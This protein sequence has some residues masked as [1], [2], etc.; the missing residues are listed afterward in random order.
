MHAMDVEPQDE[1][2]ASWS[3]TSS[4]SNYEHRYAAHA[5]PSSSVTDDDTEKSPFLQHDD[6]HDATSR[7]RSLQQ[8]SASQTSLTAAASLVAVILFF[9]VFFVLDR[10][11]PGTSRLDPTSQTWTHTI[12]EFIPSTPELRDPSEYVLDPSW[13]FEAP[14]TVR[15]YHW[16]IRDATFNPDGIFRPMMLINNKFPG[17]LIKCNEGDTIVVHVTN[18]AANATAI[19]FHGMFQNGTNSMDG[20]VGVTQCPIA[21]NATFTYRFTVKDQSGTYWYHAHHSVQASDG[22]VGPMVVR[23]RK[24]KALAG[25]YASDRVVMIQDHYHNTSAELLMD[26]LQPDQ[27]NDEPVPSS[28]LINGQNHRDCADFDGWECESKAPRLQ[29]LAVFDMAPNQRHRLRFI[30]TGAFAEFQVEV[31]EHPFYVTEVDGTAVNPAPFHRLNIQPAQRYSVVLET[32]I[33]TAD[34]F[35]MRARMITHCFSR[36]NPWLDPEVRA[37]V[38][39]RKPS[40]TGHAAEPLDEPKSKSWDQ[41]I[42]VDCRDM[43]TT[44]LRPAE[45]VEAPKTTSSMYLRANFEIGAWRLSR[46]FFNTST[47][48]GNIASPSLYRIVDV[49]LA[50]ND[51][52]LP[53]STGVNDL[54]FDPKKEFVYQT[55]GIQTVDIVISNFDDG[56]HPFHLHGHKF[57][58][59]K[60]SPT[61]YPPATMAELEEELHISGA[62]E[63]PLRRDTVT[64]QAY[65]WVAIRVV[66]DNPGM[67]AFHCH[68]AWHAEAGMM[69]VIAARVDTAKQWTVDDEQR[70]LCTLPGVGKGVRPADDIWFGNFG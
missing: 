53:R 39:Y 41:V 42:D 47:W 19:H 31:D 24:E 40:S 7:R 23:S 57:F 56:A 63:N 51:T 27:E 62:L 52:T 30:N 54:V 6:H 22:L 14:N 11:L 25:L 65:G 12:D 48:R 69:M 34:S 68:N 35:W 64:V 13:D 70:E 33:T 38:R 29:S 28:G 17:P 43:D 9:L 45:A 66:L 20:T 36:D 15:E 50:D 58:V 2:D 4:R 10:F 61:G 21:P 26:Y 16:T 5:S 55:T 37:V 3:P 1:Q 32:N 67:W 46:G 18:E 44:T 59:L 8:K 60:Q 49:A